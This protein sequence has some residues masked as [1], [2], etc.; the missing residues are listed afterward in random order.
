MTFLTS[1]AGVPVVHPVAAGGVFSLLWLIVALPALGAPSSCCSAAGV[2][3]RWAHL[4]GVATV[5]LAS[6]VLGACSPSSRCSAAPRT[7]GR[8]HEH[9][10]TWIQAGGFNIESACSTTSSRRC[11]CC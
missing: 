1:A 8:S 5:A 9:L 4:L 3:D 11:S 7:T 6:F 10:Y 2:T